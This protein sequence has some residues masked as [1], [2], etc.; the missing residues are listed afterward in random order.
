MVVAALSIR[1]RTASRPSSTIISAGSTPFGVAATRS[2]IFRPPATPWHRTIDR[3]A[4][5][6]RIS[7]EDDLAAMFPDSASPSPVIAV[8]ITATSS[9]IPAWC[10]RSSV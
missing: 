4:R 7:R 9:S 3:L 6:V 5:F 8:P 2:R 1:T 10:R